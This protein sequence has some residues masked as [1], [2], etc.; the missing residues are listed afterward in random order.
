MALPKPRPGLVIGYDFLFREQ[1]DARMANASKPHPAAIVIVDEGDTL[2]K[3]SVAAI[4]HSQPSHGQA[5]QHLMLAHAK[6]VQ[7]GLDLG[8]RD[9]PAGEDLKGG[10][11]GID[12]T[13][14]TAITSQSMKPESRG[15]LMMLSVPAVGPCATPPS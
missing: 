12:W 13:R 2:A 5:R 9:L 15:C 4:D 1:V 11:P 7:I 8:R 14:S 3:A 10:S 6:F